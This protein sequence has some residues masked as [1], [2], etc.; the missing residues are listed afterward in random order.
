MHK[1]LPPTAQS[2]TRILIHHFFRRFFDNDTVQPD[3]DTQTTVV[4]AVA[5]TAVP[6]LM[7]AF[8][9]QNYYTYLPP[10]PFW[11][12][13]ADRYFFVLFSFVAIGAVTIFEWE[14]LF[15]DRLDFLVLS[16]LP[17]KP[18]QMLAAKATALIAF[19]T[20]FLIGSNL[21]G[22]ILLP[23]VTHNHIFHQML[24]HSI[25]TLLAG[26][27][28]ALFFLALGGV[29][30]CLLG[31]EHFRILSPLIQ[32]LSV[33]AL[34]LL[35]ILFPW[36]GSSMHLWLAG[37]LG[38]ARFVPT[39]WFLGLYEQLLDGAAAPAFAH[40]MSRYAL[41]ATAIA[42]VLVLI[43]Y[44]IAWTRMRRMAFEGSTRQRTQPSRWLTTL[45]HR[46]VRRPGERA[47]FHFIG[48]TIR[49]NN[50]YQVYLAIYAGVGLA[51]AIAC[52]VTL[53]VTGG[54]VRPALS[55]EGVHAVTPLLLFWVIAGLRTAFAFPLT[56]T[57]RWV[58]RITGV[59]LAEC[60][61]AARRWVL[62]CALAALA[63]ILAVLTLAHW[64][65]RH[66][67]V[68]LVFG[69]ALSLLLTDAFFAFH[70][71]V[72]FTQPRM[73]GRVSFPLML[74]LYLGVFPISIYEV[75]ELELRI[76][77]NLLKLL[78][79]VLA[80]LAIH[81]AISRKHNE[82]AEVEEAMEGYDDEFQLLGLSDR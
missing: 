6:G 9:L 17:I 48:Q 30:L 2:P 50:R 60:A 43:T 4:R 41:R 45:L 23:L 53:R 61:A 39:L 25:A 20:L 73:P 19:L 10:R 52:A 37:P 38:N 21:F 27:F 8:W 67:L 66:L 40:E 65:A 63:C 47:V 78:P 58:F 14:M 35:M 5:F 76:E 77:K 62:L 13:I 42:A 80:T 33:I 57:S 32:M 28:A 54:H 70:T 22:S 12:T 18:L 7:V 71:S 59:S 55:N 69:L 46:I 16:P 49:R 68:Q 11:A 79:I 3:G 56:L 36:F 82:P 75:V 72:P 44:P 29:L 64:D 1:S 15:P 26:T 34:V 31:A 81:W 74:T 24:A 51:L